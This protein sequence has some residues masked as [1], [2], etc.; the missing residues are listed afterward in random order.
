MTPSKIDSDYPL[1]EVPQGARKG[2]F[3][4]SIL[5][6]G[7]T[8]FTA[9][10]FAGG[11]IGMAF[12]FTSLIWAAVIGNLLLGL[13]AAVLGY[14]ACRSGLNSV[15]MGRFC[16]GEVGSK[17]SDVLL[18]FTQIGWYAWGTA[19]IAIV[20]VKI[21]GLPQGLTIPLMVL[22]G[23]GFCITA[24]IGYKGL[25]MLSRVA[26]PAMMILLGCSLWIA[27]RDAGGMTALMAIEPKESMTL[28][29]AIT[30][31][32]GTFVSGA[33]Q[34]TNWTRFAKSGRVA[35][36]SSLLG[37][38]I[39]NGLMI[40]AGAYGAIVYQQPDVVEVLVLQGLSMA[41]VVMLFLNL[42]TT[43]DNTIY[44]FAAAG[45]NLLRTNRRKLVTLVGAGIGTLL[46]IAGMYEMLI[47]FLILLG[48]I[49]PPIGGVIMADFF[50]GHKGHYPK[51]QETQL[52]AFNWIGLSA[53]AIG[54]VCAYLSP[55]IA[56]IVGIA[57][58]ALAYIVLSKLLSG[59]TNGATSASGPAN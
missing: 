50:Y 56:P 32:F 18:G 51:L 20:L 45:C 49:I 14:I 30:M 28:S 1:S 35:M 29:V 21:L 53:Y 10:M 37:F 46:A 58:A 12:D 7:F 57:V 15:L 3:S 54:A 39:G 26:V 6:F 24:F 4:T 31:V 19:T 25:D 42:W 34:A 52:P 44:N 36:L 47:P 16:F 27:T 40:I 11:K 48:S 55:W 17:L 9:T 13:Y 22:F 8:F 33:T 41:A 2:L 5:L 23:F 38:F 43:Q 59:A